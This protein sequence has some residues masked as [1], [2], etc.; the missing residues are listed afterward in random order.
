MSAAL[1]QFF[2]SF[3]ASLF[4]LSSFIPF[5]FFVCVFVR[6]AFELSIT[7][8]LVRLSDRVTATVFFFLVFI[9]LILLSLF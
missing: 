9:H 1:V 8:L 4:F 6:F 2:F 3:L 7:W 5:S